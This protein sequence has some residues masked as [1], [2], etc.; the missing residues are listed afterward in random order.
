MG[1]AILGHVYTDMVVIIYPIFESGFDFI[2]NS[3]ANAI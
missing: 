1:Q 3:D 2:F